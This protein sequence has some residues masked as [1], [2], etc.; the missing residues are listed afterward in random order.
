MQRQSRCKGTSPWHANRGLRQKE[1]CAKIFSL[2]DSCISN[3]EL[4]NATE[5]QVLRYLSRDRRTAK[6][7]NAGPNKIPERRLSNGSHNAVKSRQHGMVL[8]ASRR[9]NPSS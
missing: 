4:S 5:H 2:N 9:E 1:V 6:D 8:H 7:Q 3:P